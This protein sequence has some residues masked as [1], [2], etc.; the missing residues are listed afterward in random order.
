MK[1]DRKVS[2][3]V[4]EGQLCTIG[5]KKDGLFGDTCQGDS[6]GPLQMLVKDKFYLV[7]I[8]SFGIGCGTKNPGIFTRV[9]YYLDWIESIVWQ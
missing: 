5:T 1:K 7:G 9:A 2:E 4:K 3:G 6:G 8:T